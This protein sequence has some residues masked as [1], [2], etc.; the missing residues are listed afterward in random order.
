MNTM[1]VLYIGTM[2][3]FLL[4]HYFLLQ[5]NT[6]YSRISHWFPVNVILLFLFTGLFHFIAE[7]LLV[8]VLISILATVFFFMITGESNVPKERWKIL[9][10]SIILEVVFGSYLYLI[11]STQ[12][13]LPTFE[14]FVSF[15][16]LRTSVVVG[17]YR[18]NHFLLSSWTIPKTYYLAFPLLLVSVFYLYFT[19]VSSRNFSTPSILMSSMA[20]FWVTILLFALDEMIHNVFF[21]KM[22]NA[23]LKEQT[24]A[25]QN[26]QELIS[27]SLHQAKSLK[28][29][30][31]N[32]ILVLLTL[33]ERGDSGEV[34]AYSHKMLENID[35]KSTI[36]TSGHYVID[37]ILNYKLEQ[38]SDTDIRCSLKVSQELPMLAYDL[39]IILGN[40]L[41]N[42]VRATEEIST[43][44]RKFINILMDSNRGNF[45]LVIENSYEGNMC[46]DGNQYH[47]TKSLAIS[48][49]F[50]LENVKEVVDKYGGSLQIDHEN[51]RFVVTIVLPLL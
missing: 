7:H 19:S 14:L 16:V 1:D 9:A 40:L 32:Q 22:E 12:E 29:D 50:G 11:T 3:L 25:F 39:T 21:T 4:H 35:R 46:F 24:S 47:S 45:V 8:H 27:Q 6:G 34:Q 5:T 36:A 23:I 51:S 41:D 13:N 30:M 37:S 31:K 20:C 2:P 18:M 49:G 43:P 26:Q 33:L 10:I 48:H 44:N 15:S 42:A 28:H 17:T 38:C